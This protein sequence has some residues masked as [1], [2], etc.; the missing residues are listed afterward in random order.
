MLEEKAI[1]VETDQDFAWVETQR[2]STCGA[3]SVNK[4]CGTSVLQK[5]LGQKRT[6]L[7]V[8]NQNNYETGEAVVLGLQESALIKGSL[9][10]YGLPLIAMFGFALLGAGIFFLYEWQYTEPAKIGF[11]LS[12]LVIGFLTIARMNKGISRN[13]DFQAVILRRLETDSHEIKM[14]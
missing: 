4:G 13:S 3:C 11:S 10:M 5:V 9:L 8:L 2:Q 1:I 14:I 6:R 12:G 7:K